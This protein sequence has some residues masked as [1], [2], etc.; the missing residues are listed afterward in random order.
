MLPGIESQAIGA[1]SGRSDGQAVVEVDI[2]HQRDVDRR[3]DSG[4]GLC[5]RFVRNRHPNDFAARIGQAPN[6]P[7][8]GIDI[9]GFC[10]GHGLDADGGA[11]SHGNITY[12]DPAGFFCVLW[13]TTFD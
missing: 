11:A 5:R 4:D 3:F 1:V 6:L 12:H 10:V 9:V 8:G 13:T 2:R 7:D